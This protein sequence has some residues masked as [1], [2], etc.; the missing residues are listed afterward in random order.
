MEDIVLKISTMIDQAHAEVA[1]KDLKPAPTNEATAEMLGVPE[2]IHECAQM[3]HDQGLEIAA[4]GLI[5]DGYYI[6]LD[7]YRELDVMLRGE[8]MSLNMLAETLEQREQVVMWLVLGMAV[9]LAFAI[10]FAAKVYFLTH[11]A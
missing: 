3:Y 11:G 9:A 7:H 1:M 10:G 5:T 4:F 6:R 8:R 2:D